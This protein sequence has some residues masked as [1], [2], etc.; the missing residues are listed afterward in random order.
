M[1]R[2]LSGAVSGLRNHQTKLD[3]VGNNI[4]NVNTVGFKS[5]MARFQDIFSQTVKGQCTCGGRGHES[6][7]GWTW[8]EYFFD[9]HGYT[10]GAIT[11][12]S[13]R[14]IWLSR[15][16]VLLSVTGCRIFIPGT[17]LLRELIPGVA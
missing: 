14:R 7:A 3:V 11:S 16:A 13:R 9:N 10:G 8:D 6:R 2:S 5:E 1:L 15:E 17:A 12:T 4:A